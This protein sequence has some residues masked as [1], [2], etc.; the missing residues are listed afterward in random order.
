MSTKLEFDALS[1]TRDLGGM[2]TVDGKKIRAGM[3]YRSGHLYAASEADREKLA[4]LVD[5]VVDFRTPKER[6]EKPD[7]DLPGVENL[8]LPIMDSLS[9]GVTREKDADEEAISILIQST[10][11]ARAHMIATYTGFVTSPFAVS[12]YGK[13]VRLL[14]DPHPRG[15]LWHC[16]AG[17]DRAGFASVIVEELLGVDRALIREDYLRTNEYLA[18]EIESLTEMLMRMYGKRDAETDA[19]LRA[20]FCADLSYLDALY[21]EIDTRYGSFDGFLSDGLGVTKEDRDTLRARYLE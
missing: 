14:L 9:A 5:L 16:T 6:G 19:A 7:P 3:L 15:I 10:E 11:R 2:P 13:F 21:R 20:M 1:N 12:Q 18:E 8:H 17:K 4:S